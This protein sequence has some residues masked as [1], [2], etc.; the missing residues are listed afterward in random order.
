[1]LDFQEHYADLLAIAK[2]HPSDLPTVWEI[3]ESLRAQKRLFFRVGPTPGNVF[4]FTDVYRGIDRITV[5]PNLNLATRTA[6]AAHEASEAYFGWKGIYKGPDRELLA[7]RL[8]V[9]V[10]APPGAMDLLGKERF[11]DDFTRLARA[12]AISELEAACRVAGERCL[13]LAAFHR[14]QV[15]YA[16]PVWE[17]GPIDELKV[18]ASRITDGRLYHP[19]LKAARARDD[20]GLMLVW[21]E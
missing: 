5:R 1:M 2:L 21:V 8:Q 4:G 14:S 13:P 7:N 3:V 17:W 11:P 15:F 19:M 16:G 18:I 20:R 6:T 9:Y 12:F 10:Q